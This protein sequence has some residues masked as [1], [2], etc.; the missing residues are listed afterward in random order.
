M[1]QMEKEYTLSLYSNLS[2][3]R[4]SPKS[5]VCLVRNEMSGKIYIKKELKTYNI[6]VFK[7]LKRINHKNTPRIYEFIELENTLYIIEEFINGCTLQEILKEEGTL[8][9]KQVIGYI[10][11]LC[12]ILGVLHDERLPI[13]HRDIKP[14]NIIISNDKVLKLIDFDVSRIYN[15]ESREDTHILG[16]K[17]YASPEQFGFDQTDC[18]SD[19]YSLGVL[20]NVLTTGDYPKNRKNSGRLRG[21]IEK[22]THIAAD[23]RYTNVMELSEELK[24]LIKSNKVDFEED[25]DWV[26]NQTDGILS[27]GIN[28]STSKEMNGQRYHEHEEI[29]EVNWKNI[30]KQKED[31]KIEKVS[32][33]NSEDGR[34]NKVVSFVKALPGFRTMNPVKTVIAFCW[35]FLLISIILIGLE[36][37]NVFT[38]LEDLSMVTALLTITLLIGDYKNIQRRLPMLRSKN[39]AMVKAGLIV[40]SFTIIIMAG[41]ALNFFSSFK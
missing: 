6:E 2:E 36:N 22:C 35:Y 28:H 12:D 19:I 11:E 32:E 23:K 16:T 40:Y 24:K 13:I 7:A 38:L 31:F 33:L 41:A 27:R 18:R 37:F 4:N 20:M 15:D 39:R 1:E 34:I 29:N 9:E 26:S 14:S 17:G 21:V 3:L 25:G 8:E 10:L 30:K 5:S